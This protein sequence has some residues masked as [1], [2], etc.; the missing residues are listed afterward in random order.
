[1]AKIEIN[2]TS[3]TQVLDG[4][5]FVT[6]EVENKYAF[7]DDATPPTDEDSFTRNPRDQVNGSNGKILWAKSIVYAKVDVTPVG[8]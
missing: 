7:T 8:E 2:N 1:M 5:G 3:Y 4:A 6:S